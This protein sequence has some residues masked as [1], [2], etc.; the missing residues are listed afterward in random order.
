MYGFLPRMST[1]GMSVLLAKTGTVSGKVRQDHIIGKSASRHWPPMQQPYIFGAVGAADQIAR[2]GIA[3][4]QFS[5]YWRGHVPNTPP[6]PATIM[7]AR[8]V[9]LAF[10]D[11]T[12]ESVLVAKYLV[13]S[14]SSDVSKREGLFRT[15]GRHKRD[16]KV[17]A[18]CVVQ[19]RRSGLRPEQEL[20]WSIADLPMP[21]KFDACKKFSAGQS[22]SKNKPGRSSV[23][24]RQILIRRV[25]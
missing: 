11:D 1:Q 15:H 20:R 9:G 17:S 7:L 14:G 22:P 10:R 5:M 23:P 2:F 24:G 8:S 18:G 13:T 16:N 25:I 6:I 12:I 21:Q 4:K 19:G 3:E